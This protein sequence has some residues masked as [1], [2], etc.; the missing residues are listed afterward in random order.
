MAHRRLTVQREFSL[1]LLCGMILLIGLS[2]YSSS[3]LSLAPHEAALLERADQPL[4][5]QLSHIYSPLYLLLLDQWQD[6]GQ[7]PLWLRLPGMLA[8]LLALFMTARVMRTLTGTH[9]AP[10]GLLLL[11][12]APFLVAQARAISPATL[13]LV[14]AL[15]SYVFF[16]EY[17]RVGKRRW[18]G[19]WVAATILSWGIQGGLIFLPL[20]QSVIVLLYRERYSSDKQRWWWLAQALVLIVFALTFWQSF[21]QFLGE[22]L[23]ALTPL[24]TAEVVP[25]L[26]LLSTNLALPEALPGML[27][28]LFLALSGLLATNWRKNPRHGLLILG[29]LASCP[30]YLFAPQSEALLLCTLP[31][32]FGLAAMGLRLYPNWARQ[33]L[34][35]AVALCYVWSYWHLY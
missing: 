13:A 4:V 17:M 14:A 35:T 31:G 33:G 8:G 11:A 9:A 22:R 24:Q 1:A 6:I 26:A 7:H 16:L 27:L 12:G 10:S 21:A 15:V 25:L 5:V 2:L 28:V 34:W 18:L 32:L 30:L 20:L 3:T 23:T 29:F 19:G